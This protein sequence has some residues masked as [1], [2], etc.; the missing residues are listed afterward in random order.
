M[1][2]ETVTVTTAR[3][4]DN[5]KAALDRIDMAFKIVRVLRGR[6]EGMSRSQIHGI[7]ANH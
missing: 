7:F 2:G 5:H 1:E 4:R 3:E 6:P